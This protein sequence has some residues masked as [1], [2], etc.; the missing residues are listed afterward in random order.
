MLRDG[1][2]LCVLVYA[3]LF[4]LVCLRVLIVIYCVTL[5]GGCVCVLPFVYMR[6]CGF[7]L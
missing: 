7:C 6:V 5:Y 3:L 4:Y 2:L 1:E